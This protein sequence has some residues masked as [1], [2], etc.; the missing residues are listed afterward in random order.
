MNLL[1]AAPRLI[2]PGHPLDGR[3]VHLHIVDGL[4]AD[5]ADEPIQAPGATAWHLSGACVS[6]GWCDPWVV[7]GEPGFEHKEDIDSVGKAAAAGGF[8]DIG[9]LP[10]TQPVVQTREAVRYLNRRQPQ[11]T[12]LHAIAALTRDL[13]GKEMTEMIDLHH[14][15]AVAFSDGLHPLRHGG[16][17]ARCLQYSQAFGGII[18]LRPDDPELS[19]H[20]MVHEGPFALQIGLKGVPAI[21]EELAVQKAIALLAYSG[22]RLHLANLSTAGAVAAVRKAKAAGLAVTCDVAVTHLAF[23]D[24]D[25]L[26]FDTCLKVFPPLRS[27]QDRQ[28]LLAGLADDTI[29]AITAA[30]QPQDP[31]SKDLEFD[32]AEF[33]SSGLETAFAVANTFGG[34]PLAQLIQ[35][36]SQ[37]PRQVLGLSQPTLQKGA[38]ASLTIF[39]P[40]AD[41][42]PQIR[43]LRSKSI[44]NPFL[45]KALKGRVLGI[46]GEKYWSKQG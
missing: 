45:G 25:M 27:E 14:A 3:S 24:E 10:H 33:G 44:H 37:G 4:I 1:L 35:K 28:A 36:M 40:Q 13:A 43:D 20:R 41:W 5:I 34:L 23:T 21:A 18:L 30:H 12:R 38:V 6:A 11:G 9:L 31:E 26:G 17:L 42:I 46:V 32:L 15:G 19:E 16:L 22:G 39:D 29:D 8:T 2:A 7:Q